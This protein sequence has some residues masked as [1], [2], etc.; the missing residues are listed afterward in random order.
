MKLRVG[1]VVFIIFTVL[2]GVALAQQSDKNNAQFQKGVDAFAQGDYQAAANIWLIEAYEGSQD[3][4]FNLG[5][6]YL[7]GKGVSQSRDKAVFWFTRAAEAGYAEAQYNLGHLYFENEENPESIRLGA[8]WWK[9]AAEQGF[10]IAQYNYARLVFY[11]I[12]LEKDI[13]EARYWMEQ[14]AKSGQ[15]VAAQFLEAHRDVFQLEIDPTSSSSQQPASVVKAEESA[16]AP[17]S[18]TNPEVVA[19]TSSATTNSSENSEDTREDEIE[20]LSTSE[21]QEVITDDSDFEYYYMLVGD[22]SEL[23][24]SQFN[25]FSPVVVE[26]GAKVLL[27]VVSE[28]GEWLQVQVPGGVP[29]WIDQTDTR[30]DNNFLE[31]LEETKPV[32]ADPTDDIN[33]GFLGNLPRGTKLLILQLENN[34]YQV[35]GPETITGW[36]EK[37]NLS[38]VASNQESIST[39]WQSQ[40]LQRKIAA[41]SSQTDASELAVHESES[42][43]TDDATQIDGV[44]DES[45]NESPNEL[46]DEPADGLSEEQPETRE[47]AELT[48][49]QFVSQLDDK[50]RIRK[51]QSEVNT[52]EVETAEGSINNV[53][54]VIEN[55]VE[56]SSAEPVVN[57]T[58]GNDAVAIQSSDTESQQNV[59][60]EAAQKI[61]QPENNSE[62][63]EDENQQKEPVILSAQV[64]TDPLQGT[65]NDNDNHWLYNQPS[66]QVTFQ[67]FSIKDKS[68]AIEL[69]DD[70]NGNGQMF[71][72]TSRNSRWYYILWG[73]FDNAEQAN[74]YRNQLPRWANSAEIKRFGDLQTKRCAKRQSLRA[75][76]SDGLD[77]HC[78]I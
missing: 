32:Y 71:S 36:I 25:R 17:D 42:N 54:P 69:L 66:D 38:L 77:G 6:M 29:V 64:A 61:V 8:R 58:S 4:Q 75:L 18:I 9:R 37:K 52:P 3:A 40:G 27:R 62:E 7:E 26:V 43:A 23:L 72:S 53:N 45:P 73:S 57:V 63:G 22:D 21:P 67:L 34:W 46:S 15:Q 68:K 20:F 78:R 44:S 12:G 56:Q 28:A 1:V 41:L 13:E 11:G 48:I 30:V 10:G 65:G 24:F 31:I 76:E 16:E 39:V 50:Y 19:E 51:T 49:D 60:A 14:S 70:L 33:H 59:Q 5:V 47:I 74:S 2:S 35:Q 55:P